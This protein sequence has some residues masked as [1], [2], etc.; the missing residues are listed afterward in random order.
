MQAGR[1]GFG[2]KLGG[3]AVLVALADRL[4][5]EG[6][7]AIPGVFAV[8]WAVVV[9]IAVRPYRRR[10]GLIAVIAAVV[11]AAVVLDDPSLLAWTMFWTA[12]SFSALLK[13]HRFDDAWRWTQRLV[14]HIVYGIGTLIRDWRRLRNI[15]R[16]TGRLDVRAL[17]KTL[18]IP[19]IGSLLFLALFA[20]ANPLIGAALARL[21]LPSFFEMLFHALLWILIVFVVWPSLR[22]HPRPT[23][24]PLLR[25]APRIAD[26]PVRT[27][28]LSL[29]AFN[30]VF[31]L[32]NGLDLAFLWSGAALPEGV[33]TVEYVHR[34]AYTLIATAILAGLFVLIALRPDSAG[35]RSPI[36][37]RLLVVWVVQNFVLVAS[38]VLRILDYIETSMLTVLRIS[39]LAWMALVAVGLALICWRLL[40]N[41]SSAW[42]I[43]ANALAATIVLSAASVVDLGAVAADWNVRHARS[44]RYLDLCYLRDLGPSALLPL[45]ALEHRV[46]GT[47]FKDRVAFIREEAYTDLVLA[48]ANPRNASLRGARRLAAADRLLGSSPLKS[49]DTT[50]GRSCDGSII[51]PRPDP[52]A[53]T[54]RPSTPLTATTER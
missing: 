47:A 22:P 28:I 8:A 25:P 6:W 51:P 48:Q 32:Q 26:I 53:S 41:R 18:A 38:S 10:A 49:R 15:K 17:V 31:A 30:A 46:A 5:F 45:I 35:A 40:A 37:R 29:I 27:M 33:S 1:Y 52:V 54:T 2:V 42:L 7:G 12:L 34:G 39:A 23:R 50:N 3:M 20:G 14:L 21:E 13:R 4:V 19:V 11:F 43:N 36:V 9:L 24:L 16:S 44:Y